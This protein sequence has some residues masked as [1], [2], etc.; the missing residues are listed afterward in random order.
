[1][2]IYQTDIA[3][4]T[5]SSISLKTTIETEAVPPV[6]EFNAGVCTIEYVDGVG[7]DANYRFKSANLPLIQ[8][9]FNM[10]DTAS[11]EA[12]YADKVGLANA[13]SKLTN[14][15]SDLNALHTIAPDAFTAKN[16]AGT[17]L[18][19]ATGVKTGLGYDAEA[20]TSAES[21]VVAAETELSAAQD[22]VSNTA[23]GSTVLYNNLLSDSAST[24]TAIATAKQTMDADIAL[25][26]Q[27]TTTY[28]TA[29]T[30]HNN[31]LEAYHAYIVAL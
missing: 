21:A 16:L 9:N 8:D 2:P 10:P 15:V 19:Q 17:R 4:A 1:M 28:N 13:K 6:F 22:T 27:A 11:T 31:A 14:L 18:T 25:L 23:T 7:V 3:T 5:T 24:P 12:L 26:G 30:T 20:L 29:T